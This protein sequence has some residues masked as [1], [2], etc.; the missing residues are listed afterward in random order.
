MYKLFINAMGA[1]VQI[2]LLQNELEQTLRYHEEIGNDLII[3][4]WLPETM[5]ESAED[6]KWLANFLDQTG[7]KLHE[8][9]FTLG[10]H[11]HDFEFE[12]YNGKTGFRSEERRV[13]KECRVRVG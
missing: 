5:R 8:R 2:D 4:P 13:G 9:G 6:Y 11:N 12:V 3:V 10:Y 1:H 7:K